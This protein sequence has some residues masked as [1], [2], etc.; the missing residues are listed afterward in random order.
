[1]PAT[2]RTLYTYDPANRLIQ[3]QHLLV[4]TGGG[5]GG[6]GGGGKKPIKLKPLDPIDPMS[7]FQGFLGEEAHA[8]GPPLASQAGYTYDPLGN[9]LTAALTQQEAVPGSQGTG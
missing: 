1:M 4:T 5:G 8:A 6:G 9:R 3:L 2:Q 7:W